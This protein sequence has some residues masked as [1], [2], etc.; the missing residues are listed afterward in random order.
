MLQHIQDDAQKAAIEVQQL[1]EANSSLGEH[2]F[3]ETTYFDSEQITRELEQSDLSA[4]QSLTLIASLD[5]NASMQEILAKV[6]QIQAEMD[7]NGGDFELALRATLDPEE[8]ERVKEQVKDS[9]PS[10]TPID[11]DLN[12]DA[13]QE[14]AKYFYEMAGELEEIPEELAYSSE[15]LQEFTEAVLRYDDALQDADEHL[16][17]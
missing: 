6:H 17:D 15:E 8:L 11:S 3:G 13:F 5:P 7:A 10:M 9:I 4:Q 2:H 14:T 1:L 12:A 16:A